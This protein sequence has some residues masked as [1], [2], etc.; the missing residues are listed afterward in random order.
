MRSKVWILVIILTLLGSCLIYLPERD[1]QGQRRP[2]DVYEPAPS[3]ASP[4][5]QILDES[6]FYDY[7]APFGTWIRYM[8]YGYVWVPRHVGYG[9]R[10]Y[11]RGYWVW[12]DFGW[13][14]VSKERWG[15]IVYHYGRW[16][17]NSRLGWF[18]VPDIVWAP[19]WVAWRWSNIYIG[20]APLPPGFDFRPGYGFGRRDVIISESAWIFVRSR[21]FLDISLDYWLIPYERNRTIINQTVFN[22]NFRS[23]NDRVINEGPSPGEVQRLTNRIITKHALKESN[24]PEEQKV[25][26]NELLIY[27]PQISKSQSARPKE[28]IEQEKA[29]SSSEVGQIRRK[30]EVSD[31]FSMESLQKQELRRLEESQQVE[32]RET[33]NK[34][35]QEKRTLT[36]PNE[37]RKLDEKIRLKIEELKQEHG[38]E[39]SA[40][41]K[42][43]QEEKEK[44]KG[45]VK[46]RTEE[47]K[48]K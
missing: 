2:P 24:S 14:W 25:R 35:E 4:Y 31:T 34:L 12:T 15:W 43:H 10:P 46:Q 18:W 42:R 22:L 3:P 44:I 6:Y 41:I 20:W 33:R 30:A 5:Q 26:S 8:P 9:W 23:A 28:Y 17:W 32:L 47:I 1:Y 37:K 48:E 13:T 45:D 16:G 38:Q 7:L 21:Y 27:K 11:S 29:E 36:N 39:K 19:A 40:L